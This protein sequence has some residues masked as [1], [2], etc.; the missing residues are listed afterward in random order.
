MKKIRGQGLGGILRRLW[1]GY[2]E[3]DCG[4]VFI[5]KIGGGGVHLVEGFLKPNEQ[6]IETD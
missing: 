4:G 1:R 2:F 3:E 6:Q 5:K